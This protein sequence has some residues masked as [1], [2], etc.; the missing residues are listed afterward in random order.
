MTKMSI[1]SGDRVRVIAGKDKG[2]ESKVLKVYPHKQR[3]AIERVN[4]IKKATRPTQKNP[5]GGI[6]EIEGTVHVSNVMIVCPKCSQP[7]RIGRRREDGS[8]IR[9]CKKCNNDID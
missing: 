9:V 7:T 2:K 6:L 1:R 3:I 4:M 8:R 5:S